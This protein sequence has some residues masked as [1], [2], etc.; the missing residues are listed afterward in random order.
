MP[1]PRAMAFPA[2]SSTVGALR[3]VPS[4]TQE[5]PWSSAYFTAMPVHMP[6]AFAVMP[7]M[8]SGSSRMRRLKSGWY[9]RKSSPTIGRIL[10]PYS[11]LTS[12]CPR[13]LPAP[14]CAPRNTVVDGRERTARALIDGRMRFLHSPS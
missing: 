10:P 9:W 8:A 1:R 4:I 14:G 5:T 13:V 2:S 7:G 11:F 3:H 6:A 12:S